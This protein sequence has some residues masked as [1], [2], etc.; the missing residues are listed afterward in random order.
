MDNARDTNDQLS[1]PDW[2]DEAAVRGYQTWDSTI[3]WLFGYTFIPTQLALGI[4]TVSR[5]LDLGCGAGKVAR[6]MA[7]TFDVQVIGVDSSSAM[8]DLASDDSDARVSYY[9]ADGTRMSFLADAS[10]DAAMACFVFNCISD[11]ELAQRLATEVG[12]VVRPGGRFCILTP[13]PDHVGGARFESFQRG[14][15]GEK[16]RPGDLVPLHIKR[17]DYTWTHSANVYWPT[18]SYLEWLTRAG[19]VVADC[20]APV[21]ADVN[22]M[23]NSP[24]INS[25]KWV[26]ERTVAPF[27]L[28]TGER[29][30]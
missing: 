4:D 12:R 14:R 27:L 20:M 25:G 9:L 16:Y 21:L 15:V 22:G 29:T 7:S 30:W 17:L 13:H 1:L 6:W 3:C 11:S 10:I 19:F 8:L 5:L 23:A 28:I 26:L 24:S 18:S 2:T